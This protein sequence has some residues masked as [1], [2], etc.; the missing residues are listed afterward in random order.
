MEEA[1][2]ARVSVQ[3][4]VATLTPAELACVV[5]LGLGYQ[6]REIAEIFGDSA[7]TICRLVRGIQSKYAKWND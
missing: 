7:A 6:Q 3:Q 2:L 5:A 1:V 4:F